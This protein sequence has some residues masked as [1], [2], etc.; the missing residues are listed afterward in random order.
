MQQR[1]DK[2]T[3][4]F[5]GNMHIIQQVVACQQYNSNGENYLFWQINQPG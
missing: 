4:S 2:C 1:P 5:A 3:Q